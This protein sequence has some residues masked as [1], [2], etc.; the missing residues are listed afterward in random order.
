MRKAFTLFEIVPALVFVGLALFVL[1]RLAVGAYPDDPLAWQAYFSLAPLNREIGVFL[2]ANASAALLAAALL[3]GAAC[4]SLASERNH[5]WLRTRF[6]LFHMALF[7]V[8]VGLRDEGVFTVSTVDTANTG[9][10]RLPDFT[11]V[12]PTAGFALLALLCACFG[13]HRAI[14]RLRGFPTRQVN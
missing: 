12:G 5:H 4:L 3:I 2:P 6:A 14:F 9:Q 8:L 11:H 1:A 7:A 10:W 13:V